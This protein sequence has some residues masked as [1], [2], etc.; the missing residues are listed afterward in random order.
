[1]KKK[2]KLAVVAI[3]LLAASWGAWSLAKPPGHGGGGG[4]GT[5]NCNVVSCAQCPEGYVL[6]SPRVWPDCCSCVPAP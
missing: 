2:I 3:V 6:A 4:G 1:M 5:Q